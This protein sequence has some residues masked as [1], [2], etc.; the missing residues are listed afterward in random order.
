M[1]TEK[2]SRPGKVFCVVL[3]ALFLGASGLVYGVQT[4]GGGGSGSRSGLRVMTWNLK[5]EDGENFDGWVKVIGNQKPDIVG[6][7]EACVT[8]VRG[9]MKQLK[10][11]YGLTYHVKYGTTEKQWIC[12]NIVKGAW[13]QAL[14]SRYPLKD[15]VNVAYKKSDDVDRG[16]MA[17]TVTVGGKNI[18]VFNTHIGKTAEVQKSEL[19]EIAARKDATIILGDFNRAPDNPLLGPIWAAGFADAD[20]H[21]YK[22]HPPQCTRTFPSGKP[23]K[24]IDYILL[25]GGLKS[26]KVEVYGTPSSDHRPLIATIRW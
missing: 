18:R 6:L 14:L 13:G 26:D 21:C 9:V 17:A 8:D 11:K 24:K 16:Y 20:K 25:R 4:N 1:F 15:A 23:D 5:A 3:V 12:R 19:A 7:Q 2:N 22:Q 10:E